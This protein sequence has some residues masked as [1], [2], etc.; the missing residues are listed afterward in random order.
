DLERERVQSASGHG[1][2]DARG[3]RGHREVAG[4]GLTGALGEGGDGADRAELVVGDGH[5][6]QVH[7]TGVGDREGVGDL[8]ALMGGRRPG[9][10][11]GDGRVDRGQMV[12]VVVADLQGQRVD[13]TGRGRVVHAGGG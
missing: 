12:V 4:E 5:V 9:L 7:V 11:N 1:V 2:V 3:G 6:G 8:V 13:A 10:H